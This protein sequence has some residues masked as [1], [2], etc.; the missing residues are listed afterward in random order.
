MLDAN[1]KIFDWTD[2]SENR[3]HLLDKLIVEFCIPERGIAL[4]FD[5]NDYTD[6]LNPLWRNQGFHLNIKLGGIEEISPES[7]LSIM[8]SGKYSNLIWISNRVCIGNTVNFVWV[9]SHEFQH[10]IQD[11]KCHVLSVA[12]SF[13]FKNLS[14]P[15]IS[16]EEQKEVL[17]VPYEFDAEIE[18]YKAVKKLFGN[19]QAEDFIR[20][21]KNSD[22]LKRLHKHDFSKTYN[23]LAETIHFFEKYRDQLEN[24]VNL[25]SGSFIS[26][27]NIDSTIRELKECI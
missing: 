11:L 14:H 26:S 9:V 22:R 25:T 13:L 4:I 7:I 20:D 19:K 1:T 12:N 17:T 15:S 23:V 18:A 8:K 21:S 2:L 24:Y 6:Y 10:F 16:I 3:K 27:L 5:K